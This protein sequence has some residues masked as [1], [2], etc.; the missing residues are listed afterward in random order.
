MLTD[1]GVSPGVIEPLDV[2]VEHG[3]D[4]HAIAAKLRDLPGIVGATTPTDWHRGD[5]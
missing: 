3:G 1:A 2:L 4:P 5:T